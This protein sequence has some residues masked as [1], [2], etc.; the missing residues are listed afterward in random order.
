MRHAKCESLTVEDLDPS[1]RPSLRQVASRPATP[2][3]LVFHLLP[4]IAPSLRRSRPI[5]VSISVI[6]GTK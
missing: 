2:A 1:S 4:L 3:A 5:Y 6:R